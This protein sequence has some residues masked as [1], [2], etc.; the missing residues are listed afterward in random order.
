MIYIH[1]IGKKEGFPTLL[2]ILHKE[3]K[4]Q[5]FI[6]TESFKR[7]KII[8][9]KLD[10]NAIEN[11][12][13]PNKRKKITV[14]SE[15][16]DFKTELLI[17]YPTYFFSEQDLNSVFEQLLQLSSENFLLL[18]PETFSTALTNLSVSFEYYFIDENNFPEDKSAGLSFVL[19]E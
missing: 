7:A 6:L 5:I 19:P 1:F 15:M 11:S 3:K 9:R 4:K 10:L 12:L 14:L 2:T 13:I 16:P 18:L 8:S 17:F